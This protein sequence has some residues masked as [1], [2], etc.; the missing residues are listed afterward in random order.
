M[1][2]KP[3]PLTP[4]KVAE[5]SVPLGSGGHRVLVND[6]GCVGLSIRSGRETPTWIVRATTGGLLRKVIGDPRS[7]SLDIARQIATEARELHH[8]GGEVSDEWIAAAQVR[9]GIMPEVEAPYSEP[10]GPWTWRQ[11]AE[12]WFQ[13]L[14]RRKRSEV[15]ITAYRKGVLV[16]LGQFADRLVRDVTIEEV[17]EVIDDLNLHTPALALQAF[18]AARPFSQFVSIGPQRLKTGIETH[19]YKRLILPRTI[20]A[21]SSPMANF[22]PVHP[23]AV[24]RLVAICRTVPLD[25]TTMRALEVTVLTGL[26]RSAVVSA[27]QDDIK[28]G[29]W[30]VRADALKRKVPMRI[31]LTDRLAELMTSDHE[32]WVFLQPRKSSRGNV[33]HIG[34]SAIGRAQWEMPSVPTTSECHAS[35]VR[36]LTEDGYDPDNPPHTNLLTDAGASAREGGDE[37]MYEGRHAWEVRSAMIREWSQELEPLITDE[38]AKLDVDQVM[39]HVLSMRP[40]S[41]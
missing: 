10:D 7:M 1:P 34:E 11:A 20:R 26:R 22:N 13:N 31:V 21:Q 30:T 28:D 17:Q 35:M 24:A 14:R 38:I 39:A 8:S 19:P 2:N 15:T 6:G 29:V 18:K 9:H 41:G 33:A 25:P 32:E 37:V 40:K 27:R 12:A 5:L 4:A 36:Y 23:T 16:Q 3:P